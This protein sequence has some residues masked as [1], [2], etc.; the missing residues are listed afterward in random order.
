MREI[1]A[2]RICC[3]LFLQKHDDNYFDFSCVNAFVFSL[4]LGHGF[5]ISFGMAEMFQLIDDILNFEF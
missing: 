2:K 1:L 3:M 4:S 5:M